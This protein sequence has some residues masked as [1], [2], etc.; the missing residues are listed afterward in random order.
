M[1]LRRLAFAGDALTHTVFPGVAIAFVAGRSVFAG[2]LVFGL[3]S[4]VLLTFATRV[5]RIDSDAA[6]GVLVGA[7]FSVGVV[8]VSTPGAP[9]RPISPRCCSGASSPSTAA[10]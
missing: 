3:L 8:V 1:L 10:S 2:A 6:L 7:F 5:P 4:A 9:T